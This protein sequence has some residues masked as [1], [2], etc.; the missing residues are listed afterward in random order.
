MQLKL[1]TTATVTGILALILLC[2]A[3]V[4]QAQETSMNA[5][6]ACEDDDDP[7]SLRLIRRDAPA[8]RPVNVP[9]V[10]AGIRISRSPM[11]SALWRS[12]RTSSYRR[13]RQ[14]PAVSIRATSTMI[15]RTDVNVG[16][17]RNAK[18]AIVPH[19]A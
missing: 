7:S 11:Q 5:S 19:G 15:F 18:V 6:V 9:V 13:R 16:K 3:G 14:P 8:R 4:V 1:G 17:T 10:H 12:R 2:R